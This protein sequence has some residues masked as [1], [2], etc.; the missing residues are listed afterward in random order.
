MVNTYQVPIEILFDILGLGDIGYEKP[1]ESDI[2]VSIKSPTG[3]YVAVNAYVKKSHEVY[4]YDLSNGTTLTCSTKHV[5]FSDGVPVYMHDTLRVDTVDGSVDVISCVEHGVEDVFDVSLDAP[6]QYVTPNGIIHHNTTLSYLVC[7][8]IGFDPADVRTFDGS[9]DTGIDIIRERIQPFVETISHN[10]LGRVVIIE[11]FDRL[12]KNSQDS[13]KCTMTDNM[14]NARFILLTNNIHRVDDAIVSRSQV[15]QIDALDR[16]Q[17]MIRVADVMTERGIKFDME[18]LEFYT[19][20]NYPDMRGIFKDIER[21]SFDGVLKIKESKAEFNNQEWMMTAVVLFQEKRYREAREI[22]CKNIKY[23]EFDSFYRLMYENI[24][25]WANEDDN[26]R[27]NALITI[28]N[29]IV[30]DG[31]VGDREIVLSSCLATLAM[32]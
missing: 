31:M 17:Y 14:E 2:D 6:H 19:N 5:V 10:E 16:N 24:D 15:F 11:E 18:T 9:T 30:D 1:E 28:K 13:L 22:V 32:L 25:W 7:K 23:E 8:E 3:D 29:H 21:F 20:K 27:D 26:K 4:T 12:S